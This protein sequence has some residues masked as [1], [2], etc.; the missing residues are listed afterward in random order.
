MYRQQH[1]GKNH[2]IKTGNK[3]LESAEQFRLFGTAP[4]NQNSFKKN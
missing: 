1:A 4:I 3:S 2:N